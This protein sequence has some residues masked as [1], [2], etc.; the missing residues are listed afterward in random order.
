MRKARSLLLVINTVNNAHSVSITSNGTATTV[1][2][3]KANITATVTHTNGT[4]TTYSCAIYVVIQDGVYCFHNVETGYRIEYEDPSDYSEGAV[5]EVYDSSDVEGEEVPNYALFKIK[6]LGSGKYSIRSMLRNDMG[7]TCS[8]NYRLVMTNIGTSDNEITNY[9]KWCI[10]YDTSDDI[11]GYYIKNLYDVRTI[12]ASEESGDNITLDDYQTI[13]VSKY[14]TLTRITDG[15]HGVTIRDKVNALNVGNSA[16]FTAVMYS[17]YPTVNGQ[18]GITWSVTDG[19]GHADIDPSTGVLTGRSTGTVT[20]RASYS[21]NY[22]TTKSATW[23]V[24]IYRPAVVLIHGRSDNSANVWGAENNVAMDKDNPK[25]KDNNH[26]DSSINAVT[27]GDE[28]LLYTDIDTQRIN[29][30]FNGKYTGDDDFYVSEHPEGGNLAYVMIDAGYERNVDLFVFNYPNEDAVVHNALKLQAYLDNLATEIRTNG[31]TAEKLAFFGKSTGITASTPYCIDIVGHSMGGLV[32]RYYIENIGKDENIRRLITIDT[33]HW[34]SELAT[35][36][37]DSG[38]LHML[39]DH[40]LE[41]NSAMYGETNSTELQCGLWINACNAENYLITPE[42][43]YS[44][45]RYTKYYAIAGFDYNSDG[46]DVDSFCV[47]LSTDFQTYYDIFDSLSSASGANLYQGI[48]VFS[49]RDVDDNV[50]SFLSQIGCT[51]NDGDIPNKRIDFEKIFVLIDTNGGNSLINTALGHL[52]SKVPHR[53]EVMQKVTE[54]L[55]E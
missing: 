26:Y 41:P 4:T 49:V 39:C 44:A 27:Q 48:T 21:M 15:I 54:F 42:L 25:N 43:N 13:N 50:V 6:Y 53:E 2:A 9:S 52:H 18:N 12:V 28:G 29:T 51:D 37:S 5:M 35:T 10:S 7:W 17:S 20:V 34:G 38:L 47:D 1:K 36:S 11:C 23:Q 40:D 22:Y 16:T 3:G 31:T 24:Y 14:W 32:A 30:I 19:T 46:L 45:N 55:S 33:P 8:N